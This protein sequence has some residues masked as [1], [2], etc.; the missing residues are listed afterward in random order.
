MRPYLF[1]LLLFS[2]NLFA[3]QTSTQTQQEID[4]LINFVN[5][6]GCQMIRNGKGYTAEKAASHI[7]RKY[8]HYK[9]EID[10]T[11]KFIALSASKSSLSGKAYHAKCGVNPEITTQSWLLNAL[12]E[13]RNTNKKLA[14][15]P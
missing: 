6:S 5:N 9:D 1:L 13:Y 12:E 2:T 14:V 7:K 15:K 4:Y 11:E 8:E 3:N 10:S